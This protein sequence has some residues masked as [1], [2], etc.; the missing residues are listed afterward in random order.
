MHRCT[1][2]LFIASN[3]KE[4]E[5]ARLDYTQDWRG[6]ICRALKSNVV[7]SKPNPMEAL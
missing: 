2:L 3:E 4:Q 5:S 1:I 6:S 7:V